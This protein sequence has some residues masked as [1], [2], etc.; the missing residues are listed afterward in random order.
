M[1]IDSLPPKAPP[2]VLNF[3]RL[4]EFVDMVGE[5]DA[6][7]LMAK[8]QRESQAALTAI[9]AALERQSTSALLLT[10]HSLKANSRTFAAEQVAVLCAE[11]ERVVRDGD[12]VRAR[13]ALPDLETA[14]TAA[15]AAQ[16]RFFAL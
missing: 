1:S 8:F 2:A 6:T 12:Y 10:V 5:E 14:V 16:R 11:I 9:R 15:Q 4:R 7:L 3:N 13:Q